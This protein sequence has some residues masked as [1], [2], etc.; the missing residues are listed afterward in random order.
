MSFV[1]ALMGGFWCLASL[2]LFSLVRVILR[3]TT[4]AGGVVVVVI[5][6][7]NLGLCALGVAGSVI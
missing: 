7:P 6:Q 2:E 4:T 3:N 5:S 1:T